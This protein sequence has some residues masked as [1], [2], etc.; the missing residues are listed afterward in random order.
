[1]V[2]LQN[3]SVRCFVK[4]YTD[5]ALVTK[6]KDYQTLIRAQLPTDFKPFENEVHIL[7]IDFVFPILK[8]MPQK[9]T[10][11]IE[12]GAVIYK[13]TRG[14]LDNHMKP[15]FDAMNTLVYK[16]DSIIVL[17]N[18]VRKFYGTDTKVIV[19]LKGC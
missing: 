12:D 17:L 15:I 3:G 9:I 2:T 6:T 4:T 11:A 5:S 18:N 1:M 14:D 10:K 7:G 19:K 13:C 8:S 16:D